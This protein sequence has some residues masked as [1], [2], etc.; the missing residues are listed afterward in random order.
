MRRT[1]LILAVLA[2]AATGCGSSNDDKTD[3]NSTEAAKSTPGALNSVPTKPKKA[4]DKKAVPAEQ[5]TIKP[6]PTTNL[7]QKPRIPRQAG[8]P[9][10]TLVK[11]DIVTGT[12][13]TAETGD[14]VTVRYVGVR[15]RDNQQFDASWDRKPNSFPFPLGAGQV[16]QGWDKGIV[17]MKV[18]GRR[19]LT[20]PPDLA[21]G[22]QGFP[23]DIL[24]NETLIFVVDLKKVQKS[25]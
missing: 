25:G 2:L 18:G 24:P 8:D 16:I 7:K 23:P 5:T 14:N 22:A 21:Y 3:S 11:Q 17:G 20:I 15:F 13:A 9:P 10:A 12:G 19:Q 4:E 6:S 1:P